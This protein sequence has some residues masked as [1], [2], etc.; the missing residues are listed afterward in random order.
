MW[1]GLH[2][3]WPFL[4]HIH[5]TGAIFRY[6]FN[7]HFLKSYSLWK[8][9]VYLRI[10]LSAF[11]KIL[12]FHRKQDQN[13]FHNF[14]TKALQLT[15]ISYILTSYSLAYLHVCRRIKQTEV[16]YNFSLESIN[17]VSKPSQYLTLVRL[18][19][20]CTMRDTKSI[21]CKDWVPIWT[22]KWS[23]QEN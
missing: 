1:Y 8:F 6:N 19:P 4:A 5:L 16:Q 9:D 17:T 3:C 2:V 12:F 18:L 20:A 22:E 14:C 11:M 7:W 10:F 23:K 13:H 21:Q 15:C